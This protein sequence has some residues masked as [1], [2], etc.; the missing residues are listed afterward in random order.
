MTIVYKI[1]AADAWKR[2]EQSGIFTG[3]AV[4][5]KDGFIHL[6]TGLQVRQT[7]ALHFRDQRDLLLVAIDAGR[8]GD[9]LKYE[10]SRGGDRF[11]HLYGTLPTA[12]ALWV[13]PLPLD[14]SGVHA[15]PDSLD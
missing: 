10:P 2:A 14:A 15:F 6:S 3:S 1:L 8:L 5:E 11:P 12:A 9:A 4:D 7:A 13:K